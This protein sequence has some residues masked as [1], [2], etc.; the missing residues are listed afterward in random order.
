VGPSR[1][2][3]IASLHDD[4]ALLARLRADDETAF[5]ELYRRHARYVAG[6]VYS[7]LGNDG[8]LD[9]VVQETFVDAQ[10]GVREIDDPGAVR[11]WLVVIAIR[12]V[13]RLLARRRLRRWYTDRLAELAPR[14][15]DPRDA[16]HVEDVYDAL[17]RIAPPLRI[18]WILARIGSMPLQEV[19]D[20]CEISLA[21]VKRRLADADVR[22]ERKLAE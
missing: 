14:A 12:R 11:R 10:A 19:A 6:V 3:V 20:V 5:T 16:G 1:T 22:L 21:T 18:V 9:D 7:L 15:C 17:D 13:H 2:A 4:S 8:D